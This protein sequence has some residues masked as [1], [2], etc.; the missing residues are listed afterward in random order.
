M[1]EQRQRE[2]QEQNKMLDQLHASVLNTKHHAVKIGEELTEHE[3]M[4][5]KLQNGVEGATDESRRQSNSVVQLLK[6]TKHK[7]FYFL[8]VGLLLIIIVL[9]AI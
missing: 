5:G 7:G 3:K 4:L 2:L 9:L 8:V 1:L 6:D